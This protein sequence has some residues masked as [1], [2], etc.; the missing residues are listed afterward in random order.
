[1]ISP[2]FS[3]PWIG[4]F[5]IMTWSI[6]GTFSE[7]LIYSI[8]S[9]VIFRAIL[10]A[11]FIC[12]AKD[13]LHRKLMVL[14]ALETRTKSDCM[15][16]ITIATR[17]VDI[18]GVVLK[19]VSIKSSICHCSRTGIFDNTIYFSSCI[20]DMLKVAFNAGSSQHGNIRLAP[21]GSKC[22]ATTHLQFNQ[23]F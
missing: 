17:Y 15:G 10:C 11:K 20:T 13:E 6:F 21:F 5:G 14:F 8:K 19:C 9:G 3:L 16:I 18:I 12:F 4:K 2:Q 7:L 22:V 23:I 1:M